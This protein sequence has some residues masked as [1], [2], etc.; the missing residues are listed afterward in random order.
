MFNKFTEETKKVITL[1]KKEM[2][3][4]KHPYLGSEHLMLGILQCNN[5]VSN[6]LKKYDVTYKRY[7]E[8]IINLIGKGEKRTEWV[9]YT[10]IVK[11]IFDRAIDIS[12]EN[13]CD[14]TIENLFIALIE[15]GDGLANRIL[16]NLKVDIDKLYADFIFQ[17]PRKNKKKKSILNDIGVEFTNPTI[18]NKFDPVIG[19]DKEINQI[20]E[21]L[22]RKNKS[23]P[24][25][26]GEAGV[27]KTAIIEEISRMIVEGNVPNK[28]K[29]KKIINLDMSSAVAGTKYRGE[30]EEKIHKIIKEVESD[31]D[32]ILFIDEVH[33]I[34][35][36]GGAEGAIDASN[37]IKPAL[38][39][40]SIR[41]IGATT[42]DEYK[43]YI[44]KDKALERRFKKVVI[45]EP[46]VDEVKNIIYK[47]RPVYENYHHVTI[48]KN[49]LDLI[50]TLT[51]KYIHNYKNPD[52]T[53]DILDEVCAHANLK[54][55]P[56]MHEYNELS[57]QL[58]TVI[59]EKKNKIIANDFKGAYKLKQ[60]ENLLTT[61]LNELELLVTT[62]NLNVVTKKDLYDVLNNKVNIPIPE[63]NSRFNHKN[64]IKE[65][66][67]KV[68][69]QEE[70]I[71]R[72]V[73]SYLMH[74]GNN[75]IYS[76]L[77]NGPSGVGK[78]SLAMSF[79][80]MLSNNVLRID[81][82]EYSEAHTVSKLIGAPPGYVGYDSSD[83]LFNSIREYP[84]TVIVL[85]E[86]E[87]CHENILNIFFQIL[88]NNELKDARGNTIYF[89]HVVIIMT[90]NIEN[91]NK[92]GFD[93]SKVNSKL[94]EYFTSAF[95]N[96]IDEII[97]FN[98]LDE[99][100]ITKII[101]KELS[102]EK[103]FL[104]I[105]DEEITEIIEKS[106]Y[107]EYG[108]RQIKNLVNKFKKRKKHVKD[109]PKIKFII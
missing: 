20:I 89:N 76:V 103:G 108:A 73:N 55:N 14:V 77:F 53:I 37:I 74:V 40:G 64:F 109:I 107:H 6:T 34:V 93:K 17:I 106:N 3:D 15:L 50:I 63:L 69:G 7:R 43:K 58:R 80:K 71:D 42:L 81:M 12:N 78:T 13:N 26:I 94:N 75:E 100:I 27:G 88:D 59:E 95:I 28:L 11:E 54:E 47:L 16:N 18:C 23:N 65:L 66:N 33:T 21:I 57:E 22:V 36:A 62:S 70:A 8:E 60:K 49:I 1:A 38:A 51:N 104:P 90:T 35:G 44:E 4:L 24:L 72:L 101:N 5:N 79:A 92:L 96:R 45:K 10:P 87:K 82:S 105:N 30:F 2:I 25:L 32:I 61:K 83:Y 29:N 68:L 46:D 48:K 52:K 41:C 19:R 31:S 97:T 91:D 56:K 102:K 84:F 67:D 9:L 85:D 86:I 39:R 99:R 98:D